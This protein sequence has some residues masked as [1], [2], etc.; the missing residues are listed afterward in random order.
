MNTT[1]KYSYPGYYNINCGTLARNCT[2]GCCTSTG[3]CAITNTTCAHKYGDFVSNSSKYTFNAYYH[4]NCTNTARN[5]SSGCCTLGGNCAT[6]N[7]SC[8]YEYSDYSTGRY[9]Y[10]LT[11]STNTVN[12]SGPVGAIAGGVVGGLVALIVFIGLIVWCKRKNR[13]LGLNKNNITSSIGFG[14]GGT[15]IIMTNNNPQPVYGM[16]NGMQPSMNSMQPPMNPMNPPMNVP[17]NFTQ[18]FQ[19]AY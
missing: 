1:N 13:N 9:S 6:S 12:V 19:P 8:Y 17:T 16:N 3:S 4:L 14:N 10:S 2:S 11:N 7:L 5:C 18:P 15:T